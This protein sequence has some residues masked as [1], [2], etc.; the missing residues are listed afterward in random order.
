MR[1]SSKLRTL[2]FTSL[3]LFL[4]IPETAAAQKTI[5]VPGDA[6]TIQAG[7]NEAQNGDTVLVAPGTYNENIDFQGKSIM[8]TSE[9][10]SR[11]GAANTII[12][13]SGGATVTFQ[14]NEPPGA[15]LSGFTI[16]HPLPGSPATAGSGIFISGASPTITGNSIVYNAGYGIWITGS[17][18]DPAIRGNNVNWNIAGVTPLDPICNTEKCPKYGGVGIGMSGAGSVEISNNTIQ[19]NNAG[20]YQA[21]S[22]GGGGIWAYGAAKLTIEDNAIYGNIGSVGVGGLPVGG[23]QV[24]GINDLKVIQNLVYSNVISNLINGVSPAGVGIFTLDLT[25][26]LPTGTLT[27]V[28]NTIVAN[29][30]GGGAEQFEAAEYPAQSTIQNNIFES[31]NGTLA[32]YCV[33]GSN[34]G[35]SYNDVIGGNE[36]QSCGGFNNISADPQFVAP[37]AGNFHLTAAS[38]VIAAGNTAAPDLP[39]TDL[40]GF[41]RIQNG[42]ISLGVYEYQPATAN[43]PVLTSSANPSYIGQPVTFTT[44][45]NVSAAKSPVAGTIGFHDGAALL[46]TVNVNSAG[47]AALSSGSLSVGDHSIYAI[48]S[49]DAD[50]PPGISN[51]VSQVVTTYPTTTTL[52]VSQNSIAFGQ[53]LTFTVDVQSPA[54]NQPVT[55]GVVFYDGT[56]SLGVA[57]L[58]DGAAT[59]TTTSLGAGTH[60]I[61]AEFVHN[62]TYATSTSNAVTVSVTSDF[63]L[64]ATP[65]SRSISP[66]QTASFTITVASNSGF[67]QP[68]ALTCS[69]LPAGASCN[70]SPS[71]IQKGVGS[72]QLTIQ[73]ASANQA[74]LA[75]SHSRPR[76]LR[77]YGVVASFLCVLFL[78]PASLRRR[79]FLAVLLLC[80]CTVLAGCN[81]RLLTLSPPTTYSIVVTGASN[82]ANGALAHS[83]AVTVE[84][85]AGF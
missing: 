48:Y 34:P 11:G 35:F 28:N 42:T 4:F 80:G 45:L 21:G 16:T 20:T 46:G 57:N 14:S 61:T 30:S 79:S 82:T 37:S 3:P 69:G 77:G 53:S 73:L 43:S 49:G 63:S 8:V 5:R 55:G 65:A 9:S 50:L 32:V 71:T 72:S 6:S 22:S 41:P 40:D 2:L 81:A 68:V 36:A 85:Q 44:S 70:F 60:T 78:V 66:G 39:A 25:N 19:G 24:A 10:S 59:F 51:T 75:D 7:I 27:V 52:S 54:S 26:H 12:V 31:T 17:S 64:S 23:I 1:Y 74:A 62:Q 83:T 58:N 33:S 84:T 56:N 47:V 67:N 13:G 76:S 18:S 15:V 38:P 29:Q